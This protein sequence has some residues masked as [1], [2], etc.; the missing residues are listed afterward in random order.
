VRSTQVALGMF[1]GIAN[2]RRLS[3]SQIAGRLLRLVLLL[4]DAVGLAMRIGSAENVSAILP[5]ADAFHQLC[6]EQRR[7]QVGRPLLRHG[8]ALVST[9]RATPATGRNVPA[10]LRH[11]VHRREA[12]IIAGIMPVHR[13]HTLVF[14]NCLASSGFLVSGNLISRGVAVSPI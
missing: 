7:K 3:A 4:P 1:S 9:N 5:R 13:K 2:K 6:L 14:G 11:A 10:R 8:A 12:H